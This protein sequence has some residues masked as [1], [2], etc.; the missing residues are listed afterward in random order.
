MTGPSI[1]LKVRGD[2]GFQVQ[3][4]NDS[5]MGFKD[6]V[7]SFANES[8]DCNNSSMFVRTSVDRSLSATVWQVL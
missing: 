5:F 8:A 1:M 6:P 3:D 2:M 4:S 7:K